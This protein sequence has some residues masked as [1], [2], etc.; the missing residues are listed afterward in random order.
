ML[1][2]KL[3]SE[4]EAAVVAAARRSGL[5]VDEYVAAVCTDA[6]SL[7]VDRAR[8]DSYLSGTPGVTHEHAKTWLSDLAH[9][10]RTERPR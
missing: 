9:G 5:S 2:V 3:P 6:I 7:E 4:L 10:T 1:T 8:L